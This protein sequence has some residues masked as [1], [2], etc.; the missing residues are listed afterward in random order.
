MDNINTHALSGGMGLFWG[1]LSCLGKEGRMG[2]FLQ[3]CPC[4]VNK[5]W[6]IL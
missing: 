6:L 2:I 3:S 5:K 4:E 1:R